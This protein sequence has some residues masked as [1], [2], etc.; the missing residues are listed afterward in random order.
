MKINFKN[1]N[2]FIF[3]ILLLLV[4]IPLNIFAAD[5]P[6][7]KYPVVGDPMAYYEIH[8]AIY[9]TWGSY[10]NFDPDR[11]KINAKKVSDEDQLFKEFKEK[12]KAEAL[13]LIHI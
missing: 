12:H 10:Y 8:P 13:S 11:I 7:I 1:L 5:P 3:S 9:K 6:P 2:R 4:F